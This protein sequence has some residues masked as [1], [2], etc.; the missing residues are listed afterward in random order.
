MCPC[1]NT[2]LHTTRPGNVSSNVA[3]Y[4]WFITVI[5]RHPLTF[6]SR[7]TFIAFQGTLSFAI[8]NGG[9]K[10]ICCEHVILKPDLATH[11]ASS[12]GHEG[13]IPAA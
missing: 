13:V 4:L 9:M 8:G 6:L 12:K 11:H 5:I 7:A 3:S 10:Q 2:I 1:T